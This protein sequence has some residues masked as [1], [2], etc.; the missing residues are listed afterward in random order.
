MGMEAGN[1]AL[2][3][4]FTRVRTGQLALPRFQ[5]YES[6]GHA[7]VV[8]LLDSVIRGRPVGAALVL[9]IGDSEPFI[10]RPMAGAPPRSERTTEHLLDGQQ[11]LTALWKALNDLYED[12]TYFA[13]LTPEDED[14]PLANSVSRWM[15]NGRRF[16]LWADDPKEQ[17]ARGF[18]PMRLLNPAIGLEEISQWCGL[19]TDSIE[20]SQTTLLQVAPLQSAV[21]EANLPFLELPVGT[22]ADVAIDVFIKLNSFDCQCSSPRST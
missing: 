6:W 13:L 12:R 7:E 5:R 14:A 22:P 9:Q 21:R 10:S 11:R 16:P 1:R 19:A 17:L 15:N 8:T 3:N 2:P 20:E 4:W 18:V